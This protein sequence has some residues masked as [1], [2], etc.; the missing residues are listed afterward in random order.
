MITAR[1]KF[2]ATILVVA[3]V[4]GETR[5]RNGSKRKCA[6]FRLETL[7][8]RALLTLGFFQRLLSRSRMAIRF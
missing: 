5:A 7:A 8:Q 2:F 3:V 4:V 1:A 6:Q